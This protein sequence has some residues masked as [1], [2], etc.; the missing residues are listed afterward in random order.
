M[1]NKYKKA[2]WL[3]AEALKITEKRREVKS[4]GEKESYTHLNADFQRIARRIRK[5][6]SEINAKK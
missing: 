3:Y 6:S 2:K 5:T 4:I 1:K